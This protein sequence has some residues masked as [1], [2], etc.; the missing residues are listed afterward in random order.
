VNRIICGQ[1]NP[2]QMRQISQKEQRILK[3]NVRQS[4]KHINENLRKISKG[5][6]TELGRPEET[7]K[8][9]KR[10][11][12]RSMAEQ[13]I[14]FNAIQKNKALI[15]S[16]EMDEKTRE[17]FKKPERINEVVKEGIVGSDDMISSNFLHKGSK[18]SRSVGRII[19]KRSQEAM[20]TGF[21]I[22]PHLIMTNNHVIPDKQ[23][24]AESIIEFEYVAND[25]GQAIQANAF[26]LLPEK[27]FLTSDEKEFDFSIIQ[28]E[29]QNER[30]IQSQHFGWIPLIEETGKAHVGERLN[31]IHHPLGKPQQ[32]S[33]RKNLL[34]THE[35]SNIYLK[36]MTDT[37][38][39]S[40]GSPVLN[41]EWELVALHRAAESIENKQQKLLYFQAMKQ[42]DE[43]LARELIE[44]EVT[45]N[46]GVRIST[47]A[48]H[49]K[50]RMKDF[51]PEQ[52]KSLEEIFIPLPA[53]YYSSSPN[54]PIENAS[55]SAG[56]AIPINININ[57]GNKDQGLVKSNYPISQAGPY[58]SQDENTRIQLELFNNKVNSQK[59]VFK[60][61]SFLE[62]ARAKKY[63]P[64]TA[65]IKAIKNNY[66]QDIPEELENGN[67]NKKQLYDRLHDLLSGTMELVDKYPDI[68]AHLEGLFPDTVLEAIELEGGGLSYAKARAHLYTWVDL[69]EDRMLQGVYTRAPISPEQLLLKDLI[70]SLKLDDVRLPKRFRSNQF[71]NCEHIVPKSLFNNE[72]MGYSDLHHL[73]TAEGATNTFRNNRP[74]RQFEEDAGREGPDSLVDYIPYGGKITEE[75]FEP[76]NNKALVARATLYFLVCHKKKLTAEVYDEAAVKT[77]ID[78]S[79]TRKP[80]KY[81]LHR[82][83]AIYELQ[84][85]R[86]P[87]IDFPEW[88]DKVDFMQGVDLR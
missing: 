31:I 44:K 34:V 86:N 13:Y 14:Q 50:I 64:S 68:T 20:G 32:I 22:S 58:P 82:N 9:L 66:Y 59:S 65:E 48:N 5:Q 42:I 53:H 47:I 25:S 61:L 36:Y 56:E 85:N 72:K 69:Q 33:I 40:S 12:R 45:I 15:D 11:G 27:L 77:L 4:S 76:K 19:D 2:I 1:F 41:D 35:E 26:Q 29:A 80:S 88:V 28:I 54:V 16:L 10:K 71:L 84:G 60:A 81:E 18:V 51:G 6:W 78:W 70:Q 43:Q 62:E 24:A 49:I 30:G 73:I 3:G 37:E 23:T 87:F 38:P 39:G 52:R 8:R 7:V 57:V 17:L 67:L 21:L 55:Y 83:E 74:Y 46:F 63:I 79:K 75:Y